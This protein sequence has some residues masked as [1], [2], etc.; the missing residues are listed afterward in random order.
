[1]KTVAFTFLC[2]WEAFLDAVLGEHCTK[3]RVPTRVYPRDLYAHN[4]KR[5]RL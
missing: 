1:M 4:L 3:C 2:L 5:H